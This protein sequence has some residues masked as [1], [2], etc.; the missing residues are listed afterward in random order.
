MANRT[1]Q[2]SALVCWLLF[3]AVISGLCGSVET[4]P[5]PS[6]RSAQGPA[7][8][9]VE[10]VLVAAWRGPASPT[11]AE[12]DQQIYLAMRRG[13]R[14]ERPIALAIRSMFS[15]ALTVHERT[16]YL[17][18][19][20]EGN[21]FTG[22]GNSTLSFGAFDSA[23][24]FRSLGAIPDA[25]SAG[26]P[27]LTVFQ[28]RLYA[29]WRSLGNITVGMVRGNEH[30]ILYSSFDL[31]AQKW[32]APLNIVHANS[33]AGPSL[34]AVNDR[35]YAVWRGTGSLTFHGPNRD[36]GDPLI[37]YASFDGKSWS[38]Q[39]L[40]LP[41]IPGATTAWGASA[42]NWAGHLCVGWRGNQPWD[43]ANGDQTIYLA[44]YEPDQGWEPLKFFSAPI[45]TS[46]F[47]PSLA[48]DGDRLWI[49]WRG[50][51][52]SER[53]IDDQ[54]LSVTSISR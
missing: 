45:P 7:L 46:A 19:H 1:D 9:V 38:A 6:A 29:A 34:A 36:P 26:P 15:P 5:F 52:N 39:T 37:Y 8:A 16:L 53:A 4:I 30:W 22:T 27:A 41:T 42:V 25:V 47:G 17:A 43:G 31:A 12:D 50:P 32:A 54:S 49:G 23:N 44:Q 33:T 40:P 13:D 14:W 51:Y 21:L 3:G 10:G 35:L 20:G 11:S 24:G 28:G 48:S 2:I 18:W